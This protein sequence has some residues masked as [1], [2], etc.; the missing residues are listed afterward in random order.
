MNDISSNLSGVEWPQWLMAENCKERT[1]FD[2]SGKRSVLSHTVIEYEVV[3][4]WKRNKIYKRD[5]H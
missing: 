4:N 1:A 3:P 2:D 5:Q